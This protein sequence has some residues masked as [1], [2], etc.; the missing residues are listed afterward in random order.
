MAQITKACKIT[1]HSMSLLGAQ[2]IYEAFPGGVGT[3]LLVPL[4]F[5]MT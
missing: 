4:K 2:A 3:D 5:I 1:Q